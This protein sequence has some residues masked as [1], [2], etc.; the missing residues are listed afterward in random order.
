MKCPRCQQ[1]NPS[2]AEFCLKC[3][4]PVDGRT[5]TP[6]SYAELKGEIEKLR[7]SLSESLEQQT[8]TAEI[9]RVISAAPTDLTPVLNT[10]VRSAARFCGSEDASLFRLDGDTLR[11]DAN[12]GPVGDI[13]GFR[14][15]VVRGSVGGR[16]VL[17]RRAVHVADLQ[18]EV[19]E[20]PEGSA[21]ARRAGH[22][23]ILSVPLLREG[24][25]IGVLQ[26]RRGEVNPFTDKQIALLQTF[27]DQAV[28]AIENV[29]LFQELQIRTQ[30]L[31]RSVGEL[32]ALSEV[33]RT[34]SSTL[35]LG[36]VLETIVSRAVELSGSDQGIVYEFDAESHIFRARATHQ[37][38]P[39]HLETVRAA[40]IRLGEGAIGR[41]GV[42]REPVQVADIKDESQPVAPQVR[43]LLVREGM[44]SL[45][46]IPLVRE[47]RLL[48]GLVILRRERGAFST[49]V[50]AILQTFANQSVLAIQNARLFR[51][52]ADKS[53]QL[54]LAS[55]HK[56]EF[57]ANM[58][59]E[60]RTPLNAIIGFSEVLSERM[61]GELNEKQ[62]EYL[63]D[64]H[65]SGQHLLS[66]INDIL[67]LS[68]IEAGRMELELSAFDLLM[69]IDN[70]L[71]LVRERAARRGIELHGSV[72]ERLSQVQA[73]ERKIRQVLLNLL[74]NAIKFTP[75]GGRIEVGAKSVDGFV[76]VSVTDTG[77][78]IA[79]EDQE[80]V[81]EEFK[82][83]GT[84][85]KKVEGTGLG[86]ALSR[87]FIELH[88]GKIWVKSQVGQGSTFTFTVPLHHG[89]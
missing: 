22:R 24:R 52:I 64:I 12:H 38:T 69:T 29:R 17:E 79:P 14:I 9:L 87:K 89:E 67:D 77:V 35:D 10:V 63:R 49:E 40:P 11:Q 84:A 18:A 16:T 78:G 2:R 56:S 46:A 85:D 33:S 23:T 26:L 37:I 62:D 21:I 61:F 30:D 50:V 70:A 83:V 74:S 1:T 31:T 59:H 44:R 45:L 80:A 15:P 4:T 19:D 41:A 68:K 53:R 36:T 72:D 32:R 25:P 66:L 51:E 88:G 34:V 7:H 81:F 8:A 43:K 82:Q 3:G 86:L 76:E 13:A 5:H 27:A 57:L 20:F 54:E 60:L 47:Q 71:M 65:A 48:G 55:Q 42:M 58:S 6:K 73:D 39:V 28:I 75:E